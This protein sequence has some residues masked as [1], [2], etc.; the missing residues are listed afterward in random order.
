M[1]KLCRE[2]LEISA[3]VQD[4]PD[5]VAVK[6]DGKLLLIFHCVGKCTLAVIA[7]SKPKMIL[8]RV[9]MREQMA[10][11][12]STFLLNRGRSGKLIHDIESGE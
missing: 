9:V 12:I 4:Q 8:S 1:R 2:Q 7:C 10:L 3:L 11:A 6:L 5:T